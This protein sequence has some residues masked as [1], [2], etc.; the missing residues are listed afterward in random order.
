M[1]KRKYQFNNSFRKCYKRKSLLKRRNRFSC[2]WKN[3]LTEKLKYVI[4]ENYK[5]NV[6]I[7]ELELA[8]NKYN[9][10]INNKNAEIANLKREISD[11]S[12][13]NIGISITSGMIII[14]LI[15]AIILYKFFCSKKSDKEKRLVQETEEDEECLSND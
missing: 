14:L 12:I 3:N 15:F 11:K 5:L 8:L 1:Q 9:N 10:T 4:D 2:E 6:Y 7:K 13:F